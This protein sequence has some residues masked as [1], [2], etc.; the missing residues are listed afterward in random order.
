[1]ADR[2]EIED[3]KNHA[4][5]GGPRLSFGFL[6]SIFYLLVWNERSQKILGGPANL[7]WPLAWHWLYLLA[8]FGKGADGL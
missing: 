7:S 8:L 5:P 2:W 1:M 3:G 4:L 6:F